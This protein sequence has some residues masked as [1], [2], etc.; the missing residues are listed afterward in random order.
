MAG[1]IAYYRVSTKRQ[2]ESG[3]GLEGQQTAVEAYS[4]QAGGPIKASYIEVET[5]KREDRPELAK[6]LA[7][8]RRSKA[9]LVVA[10]STIAGNANHHGGALCSLRRAG[11]ARRLTGATAALF[12]NS[13]LGAEVKTN[14]LS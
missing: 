2:G 6:A 11:T 3:L 13:S 12:G 1:I 4:R 7:H 5:G 10:N 8:A 9:T 14:P